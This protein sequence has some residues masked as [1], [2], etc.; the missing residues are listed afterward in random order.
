MTPLAQNGYAVALFL[1][2]CALLQWSHRRIARA[3][4][5]AARETVRERR[6]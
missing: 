5:V 1:A 4:T 6:W 2:L 3:C